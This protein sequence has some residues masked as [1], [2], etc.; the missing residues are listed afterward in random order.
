MSTSPRVH[1][2]S[3]ELLE[4]SECAVPS[5]VHETIMANSNQQNTVESGWRRRLPNRYDVERTAE[6]RLKVV[7]QKVFCFERGGSELSN[8]EDAVLWLFT[9]R[10]IQLYGLDNSEC[11][12]TIALSSDDISCVKP[13][14]YSNRAASVNMKGIMAIGLNSGD[15]VVYDGFTGT[16]LQTLSPPPTLNVH[17]AVS[18]LGTTSVTSY[19]GGTVRENDLTELL[20]VGYANGCFSQWRLD[21]KA[22]FQCS[23]ETLYKEWYISADSCLKGAE[24]LSY[25]QLWVVLADRALLFFDCQGNMRYE[26]STD[27]SISQLLLMDSVFPKNDAKRKIMLLILT[28][29]GNLRYYELQDLLGSL[30]LEPLNSTLLSAK[31]CANVCSFYQICCDYFLL[32]SDDGYLSLFQWKESSLGHTVPVCL[33]KK[34]IHSAKFY[35]ISCKRKGEDF[36]VRTYCPVDN[37]FA[38]SCIVVKHK[39]ECHEISAPLGCY[40]SRISSSTSSIYRHEEKLDTPSDRRDVEESLRQLTVAVSTTP[41]FSNISEENRQLPLAGHHINEDDNSVDTPSKSALLRLR[42]TEQRLELLQIEYEQEKKIHQKLRKELLHRALEAEAQVERLDAKLKEIQLKQSQQENWKEE[43]TSPSVARN[44][45]AY[46]EKIASLE[47]QLEEALES[48]QLL[49]AQAKEDIDYLQNRVEALDAVLLSSQQELEDFISATVE[50]N[51]RIAEALDGLTD[52]AFEQLGGFEEVFRDWMTTV[53]EK[54]NR[55][56]KRGEE[57]KE[58][59]HTLQNM[60]RVIDHAAT[61]KNKYEMWLQGDNSPNADAA[62]ATPRSRLLLHQVKVALQHRIMQLEEQLKLLRDKQSK[63]SDTKTISI[64]KELQVHLEQAEQRIHQLEEEKE[65]IAIA[66]DRLLEDNAALETENERLQLQ[67]RRAVEAAS[68]YSGRDTV[69]PVE[70]TTPREDHTSNSSKN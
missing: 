33:Y 7:P 8:S 34:I 19:V 21:W 18:A 30:R 27:Y 37:Q 47:K 59:L 32:A 42:E 28:E 22:D 48:K 9:E 2:S 54:L 38:T 56:R 66:H 41:E 31:D 25:L 39:L 24:Y 29:Q 69:S 51:E 20:L 10:N 43:A 60:F 5:G 50:M 17:V 36:I 35:F 16:F 70:P 58:E 4:K 64:V 55:Q 61:N 65:Q 23:R 6:Q 67:L 63:E 1:P 3:G 62:D 11:L 14:Y 15:C 57:V 26:F 49:M 45:E 44:Q 53:R 12:C 52:E 13:F 40:E 46:N 68:Y